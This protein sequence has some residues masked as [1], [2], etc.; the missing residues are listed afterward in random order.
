[1]T[2]PLI[3]LRGNSGCGKTSTAYLLQRQLGYGTMLVSQD[4]VRR[5]IKPTNPNTEKTAD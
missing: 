5:E 2:T 4:M 3:I 1:M